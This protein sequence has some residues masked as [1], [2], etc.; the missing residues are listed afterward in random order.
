MYLYPSKF[1]VNEVNDLVNKGIVRMIVFSVA[2]ADAPGLGFVM[3][4]RFRRK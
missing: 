3:P 4:F 1:A 2:A